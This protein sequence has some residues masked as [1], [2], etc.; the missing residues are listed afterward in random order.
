MTHDLNFKE[1]IEE[2]Q[3]LHQQPTVVETTNQWCL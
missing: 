3:P 2:N 1:L